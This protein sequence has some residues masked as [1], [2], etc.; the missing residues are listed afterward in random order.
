MPFY[1]QAPRLA[2]A[3]SERLFAEGLSLPC[4]TGLAAAQQDRVI[5]EIL[6]A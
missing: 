4:S 6:R 2:G 1:A 5:A 3:V